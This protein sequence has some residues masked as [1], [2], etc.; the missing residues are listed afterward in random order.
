MADVRIVEFGRLT[1]RRAEATLNTLVNQG[2][3]IVGSGGGGRAPFGFVVLQRDKAGA[4]EPTEEAPGDT[5][6][7]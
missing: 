5:R 3:R 6:R 7:L 1:A 4:A 2:W